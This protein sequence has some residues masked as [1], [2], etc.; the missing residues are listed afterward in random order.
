MEPV[1]KWLPTGKFSKVDTPFMEY[2]TYEKEI[3]DALSLTGNALHKAEMKYHGKFVHNLGRT[4]QMFLMIRIK[5]SYGTYCLS[6]TTLK[7]TLIVFQGIKRCVQYLDSH[8]HKP[9]FYPYTYYDGSN[10]IRLAC[11]GNQVED[12]TTQNS[13]KCHQDTDHAR[14]INRRQSVSVIIHTLIGVVFCWK[15]HIQP[16]IS[17]D[18][19]DGEIR[20]MYK[21]VNKNKV[22]RRYMK[23][24][25][26]HTGTPTLN[27]EYNTSFISI[28]EYKRV[29]PTVKHIYIPV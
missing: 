23:A 1:N 19:T 25:P 11:S 20:C 24:L 2:S 4:Q 22:I 28:V 3:M 18:S 12:Y 5:T 14:I 17:Y 10:F 13:L 7:P 29:T 27:F 21:A 9:I 15:V 6:T 26:L 16:A 8:P